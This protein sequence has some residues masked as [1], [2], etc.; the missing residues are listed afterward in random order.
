MWLVGKLL[1]GILSKMFLK[2]CSVAVM[3]DYFVA[4]SAFHCCLILD[5]KIFPDIASNSRHERQTA[6]A[7]SKSC[8]TKRPM[9]INIG[10]LKFKN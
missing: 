7:K 4:D 9:F 2:I 8:A 5:N 1:S 10:L 3:S 6:E